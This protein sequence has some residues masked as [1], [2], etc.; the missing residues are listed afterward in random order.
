MSVPSP[1]RDPDENTARGLQ[2][3][4]PGVQGGRRAGLAPVRGSGR[5]QGARAAPGGAWIFAAGTNVDGALTSTTIAPGFS[6]SVPYSGFTTHG[7]PVGAAAGTGGI[8]VPGP[9]L[10]YL[11][12]SVTATGGGGSGYVRLTVANHVLSQAAIGSLAH[13][14]GW[15]PLPVDSAFAE[16]VGEPFVENAAG[17]DVTVTGD[18]FVYPAITG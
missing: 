10:F 8:D 1:L 2:R 16:F 12:L 5:F 11:F 7:S 13:F 6:A 4:S 9:G 15:F 17:A 18:V 3:V 14:Q